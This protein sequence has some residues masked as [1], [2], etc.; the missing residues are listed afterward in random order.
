MLF[1]SDP[2]FTTKPVGDG[3][4]LGLSITHSVI[5][6]HGGFI[7][8]ESSLGQGTTFRVTIPVDAA[9]PRKAVRAVEQTVRAVKAEPVRAGSNINQPEKDF[10]FHVS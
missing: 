5:E 6:R 9:K 2:F 8:V 1:R 7:K 3:T 4:G 10:Y